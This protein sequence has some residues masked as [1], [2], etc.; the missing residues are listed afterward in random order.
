MRLARVQAYYAR[1]RLKSL[2]AT[3]LANLGHAES[4]TCDRGGNEVFGQVEDDTVSRS[5]LL[6]PVSSQ[7]AGQERIGSRR[8]I[9][10]DQQRFAR[11]RGFLPI[12]RC[13]PTGR[14]M[15]SAKNEAWPS[16]GN[17]F[18]SHASEQRPA[19]AA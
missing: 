3:R 7:I 18:E 5:P 6:V 10:S 12:R 14:T 4:G 9:L 2:R 11:D 17:D 19:A 13:T 16:G 8:T 15:R 1:R